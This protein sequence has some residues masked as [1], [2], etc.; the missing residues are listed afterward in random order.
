MSY[1]DRQYQN[2]LV[3]VRLKDAHKFKIIF[4]GLKDM[5]KDVSFSFDPVAKN[6]KMQ[7]MDESKIVLIS[8]VFGEKSFSKFRVA[9][10]LTVPVN[11][12][13][14]CKALNFCDASMEMHIFVGKRGSQ[15]VSF[16]FHRS[17]DEID[18]GWTKVLDIEE[19]SY[20]V[21]DLSTAP[22]ILLP[23]A[24]FL[25]TMRDF[26]QFH[27]ELRLTCTSKSMTMSIE[28]DGAATGQLSYHQGDKIGKDTIQFQLEDNFKWTQRFNL[29]LMAAMAKVAQ[30]SEATHLC[31]DHDT[32]FA[33]RSVFGKNSN[34][35][36][37][38]TFFIASR[39][40]EDS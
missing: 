20:E 40:G 39:L 25:K 18:V 11:V 12:A 3:E 16:E 7:A 32:P 4:D 22:H 27:E 37:E 21:P 1:L 34:D 19:E 23:S 9:E 28:G 31:I 26:S 5:V 8:L 36:G 29:K 10:D 35:F 24:E 17:E 13:E 33:I 15:M 38:L 30:C 6:L 14:V 2:P